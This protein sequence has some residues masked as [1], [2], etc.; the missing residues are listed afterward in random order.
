MKQGIAWVLLVTDNYARA[1]TFYSEILQ[2]K[3]ER[4]VDEEEFCQ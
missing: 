3:I 4:E 2:F 1:K